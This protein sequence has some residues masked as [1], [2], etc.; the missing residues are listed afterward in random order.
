MK[1]PTQNNLLK[2]KKEKELPAMRK[3]KAP[4]KIKLFGNQT[5]WCW[6]LEPVHGCNLKCGHCSARLLPDGEYHFMSMKTW[7]NIFKIMAQVSPT[8]RVDLALSGEPTLHPNLPEMLAV[9]REINPLVQIQ[10]TTNG[11]MLAK[12][13]YTHKQLLNAGANIVYVDMYAPE[14]KHI[15]L[16]EESGFNYYKYYESGQRETLSPWTYHGPELK[17]IVL[18]RCPDNWPA[19]RYRAGLM[20]TWFNNMDWEAAKK[21]G[22][23]P[24]TEPPT[25][26]CNQPFLYVPVHSKGDYLI[27]CQDNMVETAGLFGSVNEDGLNGFKK[28]W[29]G[30]EMQTIRTR[31]REKNRKDTSYCSRCC[32]TFSRGDFRHW[33]DEQVGKY[34]NGKKMV[35]LPKVKMSKVKKV[36]AKQK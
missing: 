10:I 20:G 7:K 9:A 24:V 14:E 36:I 1:R 6:I 26:R 21:Y 17:M 32:V 33:T 4:K 27:C 8:C 12:G 34:Y 25:R 19:S 35:K 31:L 3:I 2:K 18:Q 28:Y 22:L 16:A 13:K 5:P 15:K 29:F 11:T 23:K 30:K